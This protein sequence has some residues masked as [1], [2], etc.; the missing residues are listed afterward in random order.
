MALPR[1]T[2]TRAELEAKYPERFASGDR[3]IAAA[4]RAARANPTNPRAELDT[5]L[6]DYEDERLRAQY[7]SLAGESAVNNTL[8]EIAEQLRTATSPIEVALAKTAVLILQSARA[9]PARRRTASQIFDA[10]DIPIPPIAT[11]LPAAPGTH[12]APGVV[13]VFG[14]PPA[15]AGGRARIAAAA[16]RAAAE[17]HKH[18]VRATTRTIIRKR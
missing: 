17:P 16:T 15:S 11:P 4:R 10:A 8:A 9:V 2:N 6:N 3:W 12:Q 14:T 13:R 18:R 5:A 7:L 1:D